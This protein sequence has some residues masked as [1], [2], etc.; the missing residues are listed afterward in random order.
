MTR[1]SQYQRKFEEIV[2]NHN[3]HHSLVKIQF[4]R[5]RCRL[6]EEAAFGIECLEKRSEEQGSV[7]KK[8]RVKVGSIDIEFCHDLVRI[9]SD[10]TA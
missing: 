7:M 2:E 9:I 6:E 3:A 10:I 4:I 1:L 8:M 5:I